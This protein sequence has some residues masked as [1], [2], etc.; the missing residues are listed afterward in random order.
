MAEPTETVKCVECDLPFEPMDEQ[1]QCV[2]CGEPIHAECAEVHEEDCEEA[3]EEEG[4]KPE[5][6]K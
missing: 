2:H 3:D 4:D 6:E 5:E 1:Q